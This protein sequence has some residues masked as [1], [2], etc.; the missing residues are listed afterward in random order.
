MNRM[1]K[2][3]GAFVL[4]FLV[5][6]SAVAQVASAELHVTVKDAKGAVVRN[7]TVTVRN[8]TTRIER[9]QT[10]NTDGEYPFRALPPGR[11]E[12]SVTAAGFA[13]AVATEVSVTVGQIAE[14]P[15]FL[16]VAS[17]SE[18]VNV[19]SE[20]ALVETQRS[21]AATT[22]EQAR[23]ENLPINGRNYINFALTNSQLARDTAPSIGAAPTS[24][25]N[26]GGQRARSN[27][28][29][30][31]GMDNV[32]N[33]TNGIRS[34]VSQEAVQ[35]F[36]LLTNGY[37]AEYGRAS[38]GVINIITKAGSNDFHGSAFGYLRNRLIQAVNPFSTLA[39]P[40]Y[41]RVQAGATAGGALVKNRTF[42]FL[43]YE[44]TRRH[45][46]GYSSIGQN[47]FGLTQNAD[48]T[49]FINASLGPFGIP[50]QPN[51]TFV[52]PVT[53]QQ[54]TL[55]GV[56]P[57]SAAS[58]QYAVALMGGSVG[59]NGVNP[60]TAFLKGTGAPAFASL[61]PNFFAPSVVTGGVPQLDRFPTSFVPLNTLVGN[62]PVSETTDTWS[63]RLDH[64]LTAN[65]QL[66]FRGS[67]TPSKGDG[68]QV[69]AQGPQNFGQNAWSRTSRQDFHDASGTAQHIW[70]I[71]DNKVNEFRFQYSRRGLLYSY[72]TGPN[73][74]NVAVNIP[75]VAFFGREPFSYVKRTEQR[76]QT[77][78]NMSWTIGKHSIKFG[79]DVNYLPLEADFTVN[80]GGIYNFGDISL[81]SGLA[82]PQC[83]ALGL[84]NAANCGFPVSAVQAY[85]LGIPQNFIQGVGNPHDEFSNKTLGVF[86]QDSWRVGRNLTLNYGVRY[87]V[88]YTPT[89]KA[90]T[91]LA[92]SAQD[93]LGI[94][95]GIPRDFNNVAPRIGLAWDPWG[96]GKTVVRGS[97]GMFYDHPLLGL[98]FDSDV[99]DATQAPQIVL[100]GG[101]P[102]GCSLNAA[103]AFTG[104]LACLPASF[105]YL[106]NEQRFNPAPNTD[107]V[108]VNQNFLTAGV[109]LTMLPF[110]FPTGKN[111]VYAYSNQANFT[112]EHDYGHNLS[113][114]LQYNFNGGHHLNRPINANAVRT[115][116][117]IANYKNAL[118]AGDIG[119]ASGPLSVGTVGAPC[120]VGSGGVPWVAP[121]IVNF[122]R[123]SG[124]NP[125]FAPLLGTG[126]PL[127][128]CNPA[129]QGLL[130]LD[131]LG[132]GVSVPFSDMPSNY[133]N[134][135]SVY[136]G[137]TANVKKRFSKNYEFLASYTWSHSIDDSTDLQSPLS[138]QNNYRPDLER[139]NSLFDQ[140][141]RFVF[142]AVY[143]SGRLGQGFFNKLLS[144]WTLA[145]II[146]VGSGRPFNIITGIDQNFDFGTTT[147]R[148]MMAQ[149]GQTNSCG[150]TASATEFS[151]TGFVIPACYKD[152]QYIGDLGRN[153]GIRP[154]TLFTDLR[155]S[156]RIRLTERIGLDGVMDV[157]NLINR[158]NVADVNPLWDHAGQATAAFDPRQFQFALRLSW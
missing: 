41:T 85:G 11:Y 79:A 153:T 99:A 24:G 64:R 4:L 134:G 156:R 144:D 39:D 19:S 124:L 120:G 155:V 15:V 121:F 148:P 139:S 96:D 108:W 125:S 93:A 128:G 22:I 141:H 6:A 146:E 61:G 101:T 36:Q 137:F 21:S 100:F 28:V 157:F 109:P 60:L 72:S 29:N 56:L 112:I 38:G 49:R 62:F 87:D 91:S 98:A 13:K 81:P 77:T 94:T 150:Q 118:A 107:S 42:Y 52:V 123:P 57:V 8:E 32:D 17:V 105:T 26:V 129:V 106:P 54:A 126:G 18:V 110:G 103:N 132:Y 34:T 16:Q 69:N 74:S 59:I 51:G 117:L 65:Q 20:A 70:S 88:E 97:F 143:Q 142:S 86:L 92:Q 95:Q 68:I 138:P 50:P 115:D 80:F 111:F 83:Q 12:L 133:S 147:D 53:P 9:T 89:F 35:E 25:L 149:A 119:A 104:R 66:L 158:R 136:H 73:G 135:S 75:G 127:N 130:A 55:L 30:V 76:Y 154:M 46:S 3:F 47:N 152:G 113:V 114:S 7:A 84:G 90:A 33:S 23:I 82:A 31:D 37:S 1:A 67:V 116:L 45:E 63:M 122:F 27:Q 2:L 140:R 102:S 131:K 71:G 40:A 14:L 10:A 5:T 43:S 44:T 151:P 145:P 78:D 48:I 58:A